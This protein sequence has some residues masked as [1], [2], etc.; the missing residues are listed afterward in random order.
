MSAHSTISSK[1]SLRSKS[2]A[3]NRCSKNV[4]QLKINQSKSQ[5]YFD[6]IKKEPAFN[7]VAKVKEELFQKYPKVDFISKAI[8]SGVKEFEMLFCL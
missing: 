1:N 6:N 7:A 3:N 5:D 4:N 2:P 8:N